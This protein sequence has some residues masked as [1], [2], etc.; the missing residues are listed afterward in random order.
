MALTRWPAEPHPWLL[1]WEI[2]LL[3]GKTGPRPANAPLKIPA[4]AWEF[5]VWTRWRR[6]NRPPPRPDIIKLI[7]KWGVPRSG[8]GDDRGAAQAAARTTAPG[9]PEAR[10]LVGA[11]VSR[12]CIR[13]GAGPRTGVSRTTLSR[14]S[15][16]ASTAGIKTIAIQTGQATP[17]QAQMCRDRGLRVAVWASP[18]SQ[19]ANYLS[20]LQAEGY[21]VQVEGPDEYTHAVANL[22]AGVG[23]GLSL[24]LV[25]T[26]G[27]LT[28]Y[29]SRNLGY[30]RGV[31]DD[32]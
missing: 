24:A 8:A 25:T 15:I 16:A 1:P 2:W 27:G 14:S 29:T 22:T 5:D 31:A 17:L 3:R 6:K 13:P 28:T 11:P 7:P 21:I 12:L 19:D 10:R 18:G 4:Y 30:A 32:R 20:A 23:R 9:A 26:F